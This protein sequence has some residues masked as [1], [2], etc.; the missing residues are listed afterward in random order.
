[1]FNEA[2]IGDWVSFENM[3]VEDYRGTTM[4]Q[5]Q[6]AYNPVY[7]IVSQGNPLPPPR[8]VAAS[9]LP[10]PI[11]HP[12]D[13]WYVENHLAEPY[14]S[15]RIVVRDVTV[16][17][18]N[19]GKANDNYNL[20]TPGGDDI[21]AADYMNEA[22]QPDGYHPFV[23]IGQHFCAVAGVFEQYTYLTN[24]WD[25]YQLITLTT[26]DLAI[27]GDGDSDGDVDL[28]DLPRFDECATGPA[29]N[30]VSGGC[31]P[32]VWGPIQDCLMMDLGYDGDVDLADFGEL[33]GVFGFSVD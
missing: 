20:Q 18:N 3:L 17:A 32:P 24:G 11:E 10:A 23:G 5:R 13:E 30:A 7:T 22:V 21:W 16:T 31:V 19:Y 12:Y 27:C 15:M 2:Q 26:P 29:C 1:M 33:Q 28:D 4:L 6:S 25:Y 9:E 8:I 14:E